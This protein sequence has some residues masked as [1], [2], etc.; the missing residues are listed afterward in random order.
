MAIVEYLLNFQLYLVDAGTSPMPQGGLSH[1]ED[2]HMV[3]KIYA[4]SLVWGSF[5]CKSTVQRARGLYASN[6][7]HNRADGRPLLNAAFTCW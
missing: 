7:Q 4:T 3:S 5:A 6:H 1:A 2:S